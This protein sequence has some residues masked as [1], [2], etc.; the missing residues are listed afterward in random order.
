[1]PFCYYFFAVVT[2][3]FG[4][5]QYSADENDRIVAME[6]RLFG[7]TEIPLTFLLATSDDS[8]VSGEDYE[9]FTMMPVSIL[10]PVT[11]VNVKVINDDRVEEELE[12]FQVSLR[13]VDDF[14]T[15]GV[16]LNQTNTSISVLDDDG[17]LL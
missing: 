16:N 12:Q 2:V 13:D 7:F 8:A 6:I 4:A 17:E 3:G 5:A 1:M 14:P 11:T 15:V 9:G 10:T